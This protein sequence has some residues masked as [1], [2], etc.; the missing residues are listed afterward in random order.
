[1]RRTWV[2]WLSTSCVAASAAAAVDPDLLAGMKA[3]SIGP[4]GMSGRIAAIEAVES[5]PDVVYAGAATGGLWKSINGGLTWKPVFD[6]EKVAAVGAVAVFQPNPDVVWVGTGEGNVRNSASVGNGVYR[7]RD[8][9]ETWQHLGLDG[10]ERIYRIRLHP[11]DP[12]VAYV[13]APGQEWGENAE[14]GVFRT[15]DGGA[16]WE[17]VLYVDERTGCGD[18]AMDPANPDKLFAGMWQ[19]RRWP[20]FFRSGG[21]G[22]GLYVSHDGGSRWKK[23]QEEDGLP[24]G[25][26]GRIGIAVAPSDP[27]IVYA[28]VEAAKS[29][30]LR[31]SDGGESFAKVNEEVNVAPRPFY[32][33]DIQVHPRLPNRVYS[34]DYG[35]R[36]SDDG[37]KKFE[38]LL[39]WGAIHG[40][41][42][43]MWIHP[44]DPDLM[45]V[46]DD[47][48]FRIS[49]DGGKTVQFS[50]TLPVAQ[51]YHIAVD[52]AVPYNVMGG[53]QD[54]SSWRG[55]SA[56]WEDGGIRNHHWRLVGGG[57]GY[58]TQPDPELPDVGYSMWQGGNLMRWNVATGEWRDVKPPAPAGVEL[59]FNWNSALALDPFQPGTLYYGSQ[60][61]HK[62]TDRGETWE[63]ISPDLT[64]NHPEWQ[65]Q[66]QSGGLTPDVTAAENHTTLLTI[67]PS[68]AERGV[69]W[70]GSDDGRVHVSRDGG[71]TW[72]SV[73]PNIRG[74]PADT[75]VPHIEASSHAGG[76]AFVVF[77]DHRRSNWTPYVYRTDD[78]GKTWRGLA[79]KDLWGYALVVEQ[80]PV[81]EDLLFLGTEFGLW[82]SL[83][84]GEGWMPWRHGVPTVSVMDLIIHPREHDLVIGTH[85]RSAYIL[86]DVRPLRT[87]AQAVES[88]LHLFTAPD[89][90]Q[91][92]ESPEAAGFGL[93]SGE[94]RGENRPYGA[95]LTYWLDFPELPLPDED[96]EEERKERERQAER[97]RAPWGPEPPA[98]AEEA[99]EEEED[100]E[101]KP[102][103]TIEVADASGQLLRTFEQPAF[104]GLN[105]TSWNL[106][107]DA[108]ELPPPAPWEER[109]E[110]PAGPQVPPGD[111]TVTVSYGG[112]KASTAVRVL[113]D[114]RSDNRPEDW[115]ER[116][117]A[118][119]AAGALND[120]AVEAIER[121]RETRRDVEALLERAT[122]EKDEREEEAKAA[123]GSAGDEE[124]DPFLEAGKA[125]K[126]GLDDLERRLWQAPETTKGIAAEDDVYSQLAYPRY[127]FQSSWAPPSP[128]HWAYHEAAKAKLGSYLADLNAFFESE[129]AAFRTQAEQRGLRLLPPAEPLGL[130]E[131][132]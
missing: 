69:I 131:T 104:R 82:V 74:V 37:G 43:A 58:D 50:S 23:L 80:D 2:V 99:E 3:R 83:D 32:F 22:S 95:L 13:C 60:F 120:A 113:P 76:T 19:F 122:A 132:P 55:P 124:A 48:G 34:L 40:D 94:F 125:L 51:F 121:I 16:T 1:M 107:R 114:P 54:N 92:W 119:L 64:T 81:E 4:A 126:E 68:P 63:I 24:K 21:P 53:M 108:F 29:A 30:L 65:R 8:G 78:Y 123:A 71:A 52:N 44:R 59:R 46:G 116:W 70:T 5:D 84:G 7:S 79:T 33:G 103:V 93:G 38:Q 12:D 49:R 117:S 62:S 85:G 90:Q 9:G 15:R 73:E 111:Y 28:L 127:Y 35:V 102:K 14:R 27:Q 25:D 75:W 115:Q 39:S 105:R 112:E 130:E 6:E 89:A 18:L 77:D 36:V 56:V 100:E 17:K 42:H 47:G 72:Q 26:L 67:A 11:S 41:N 91:Y 20:Y 10:T 45:Y 97:A 61:V 106:R 96:D 109:D 129:V 128:S 101:E 87:M 88:K 31:S 86:D 118:I 66:K 98:E 110:H 57:D